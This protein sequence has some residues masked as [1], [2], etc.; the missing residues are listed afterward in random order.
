MSSGFRVARATQR[1]YVYSMEGDGMYSMEGVGMYSMEGD[2]MYS[3]EGD[4]IYILW[5]EMLDV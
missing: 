1:A 2:W 4:G 5:R 3:M